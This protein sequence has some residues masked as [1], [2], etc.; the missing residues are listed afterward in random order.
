MPHQA[1]FGHNG[2]MDTE[3][4]AQLPKK[5]LLGLTPR[6]YDLSDSLSQDVE[7]LDQTLGQVLAEHE[8]E[9][10]I[11]LA[12]QLLQDYGEAGTLLERIPE[13][14]DAS[15]AGKLL[16]AFTI[17]FQ[18]LN[19][20]EQKEIVRVNRARFDPSSVSSRPES[21]SEAVIR[22]KDSGL[23][24]DEMQQLLNTIDICPTITAHPT[25]ARRRAV[26]D[27]LQA[28]A[29]VL[30][31]RSLPPDAPLLD[32]P[33]TQARRPERE[34]R[35]L[36]THLWQTSEVRSGAM[37]VSDEVRN[38]L[39]YFEN[40]ILKV[41][42]WLHEDLREALSR[43]YPE[44]TFD[45]P[46]FIQFRSWVGGDR[47]GNPNVTPKVTWETLVQHKR[48]VL[49]LYAERVAALRRL[50]TQ[51]HRLVNASD[52]LLKSLERDRQSAPLSARTLERHRDEPYVLKFL[53]MRARVLAAQRHLSRLED[54]R[55]SNLE[56]PLPSGAYTCAE[57]LLDDLRLVQ[58]SLI[59]SGARDIATY[60][61]L[62]DLVTQVK[63]FGFC[64][65]ALDV[66]QHSE[67]HE[68][69]LGELLEAGGALS[70]GT[71]YSALSEAQKLEV[72]TRELSNPRPLVSQDWEGSEHSREML[73]LFEVIR[74]AQKHLSPG[75]VSTYVISMTHGISDILEVLLLAKESGLVKW[76][77]K[78]LHSDLDVV[79]LFET[80]DDLNRCDG[81]LRELFDNQAY[82]QHLQARGDF[83]EIMLGYSDSSKDGGY[84][85]ANWA[86]FD[87][88]KRIAAACREAGLQFRL[89][90]GRGGTVGR[91]GGRANRAIMSMPVGSFNGR[92]R[93]TE[94]GEV[95]SF[96][97]GL[98]PIAHR[99]LEQIANAVLLAT[100]SRPAPEPAAQEWQD[101]LR[102]MAARSREIYRA[103]VY[104][105]SDFWD[106]YT[107]ATPIGHI[108]RLPIT[109]RPVFR[110]GRALV[111]LQD[112]R[113]I[114]W[115]FAWVQS[116]YVLPGWFGLGSAIEWFCEQAPG[117]RD[118][119]KRMCAQWPF[120]GN[121]LS[122]AQLEL[123][124]AHMPTAQMYAVRVQSA[125][126][127]RIDAAI[128]QEYRK[129]LEFV[130]AVAGQQE[131]LESA[132]VVKR[133]VEFRNPIVQP[134]S[135]LQVALLEAWDRNLSKDEET[136][137]PWRL[138][139]LLSIAGIAAAMQSTG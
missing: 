125:S 121:V 118:M 89:F 10:V 92:I 132:P 37:T 40:T 3:R 133:T 122:N 7:L 137:A 102:Q 11:S 139:I 33:L 44:H 60:G 67:E 112:L 17:L 127:G 9:S 104:E 106:F 54:S 74:L 25:E 55:S 24:A 119:L 107:K 100:A 75:S 78:G 38:A 13:L 109:S 53:H 70:A 69:A 124:R 135:K 76:T 105:D 71:S 2:S 72:L 90:H 115:V 81:L 27:K 85:A 126:A 46:P 95:A 22:L 59:A 79:P 73:R 57:E 29:R 84:L 8:G 62:A 50:F 47:D 23:S 36:L 35:Q 120:F 12:N 1:L 30:A 116:R 91:G 113:A 6:K 114:P 51:S 93:M 129:T 64:L 19:T 14:Q 15:K 4:R 98:A 16:R 80:I 97:Y 61:P 117:N 96:R 94:Q 103:L 18:L 101:A 28:V 43:A 123:M 131:L 42:P 32:Q 82:R 41:I 21:I 26:L 111:G 88:Q 52:A 20:A 128:Q 99:H 108:S 5:S 48:A 45:I 58:Q 65:A 86:L 83:Q 130:L 39:Y 63:T 31:E 134:L 77:H 110:P 136:N 56:T 34:L 138:D 49:H 66:R 68:K 87:T